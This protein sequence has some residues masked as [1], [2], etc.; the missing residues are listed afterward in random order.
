MARAENI[1][2]ESKGICESDL[3]EKKVD[4][5]ELIDRLRIIVDNSQAEKINGMLVDIFTASAIVRLYDA[6]NQTNKEKL[7]KLPLEKMARFAMSI[8][9]K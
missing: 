5:L 6:V 1:L 8:L 9:S 3:T 2:F 7:L 4:G